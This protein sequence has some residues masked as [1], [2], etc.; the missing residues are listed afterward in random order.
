V[1]E[2]KNG[3]LLKYLY[4]SVEC[5]NSGK[6]TY[7]NEHG[8]SFFQ[9]RDFWYLGDLS[10]WP[11]ETHYRC[12]DAEEKCASTSNIPPASALGGW[13]PNKRF[14]SEVIPEI[15]VGVCPEASENSEL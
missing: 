7:T 15:V 13:T 10:A 3:E 8:M 4:H 14:G 1:H 5:S 2:S 11:P 9:N 6:D 12:V